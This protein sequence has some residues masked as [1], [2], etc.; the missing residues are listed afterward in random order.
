MATATQADFARL[1]SVSRATVTNWKRQGRI[2]MIGDLV[3]VE[4]SQNRL[5]RNSSHRAKGGLAPLSAQIPV[6][7]IP[8]AVT[9]LA[10]TGLDAGMDAAE[11]VLRMVPDE[12]MARAVADTVTDM[13][14]RSAIEFADEDYEPPPGCQSWADTALF[15]GQ[16]THD[17]RHEW[18]EMT[19]DAAAWR[20]EHGI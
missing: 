2:V 17:V 18:A 20:A 6:N 10:V 9:M 3:D 8:H 13:A 5:L 4:A 11:A 1:K 16:P 19:A 12:T 15:R 14:M 7:P